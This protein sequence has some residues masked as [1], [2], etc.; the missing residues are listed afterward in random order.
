MIACI[1]LLASSAC[2]NYGLFYIAIYSNN[3]WTTENLDLPSPGA[4]PEN[5]G[6]ERGFKLS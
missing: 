4:D 3:L 6:G 1:P 2:L 5:F